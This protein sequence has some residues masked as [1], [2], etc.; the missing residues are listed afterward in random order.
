MNM[1]LVTENRKGLRCSSYLIFYI[2]GSGRDREVI[3][4]PLVFF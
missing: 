4:F 3:F 1:R 2:C